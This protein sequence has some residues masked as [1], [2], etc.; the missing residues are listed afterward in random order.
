[1]KKHNIPKA[2]KTALAQGKQRR[3][4]YKIFDILRDENLNDPWYAAAGLR[5]G[6]GLYYAPYIPLQSYGR[7]LRNPPGVVNVINAV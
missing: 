4:N 1:V 5:R 3:K 7:A 6:A 2:I